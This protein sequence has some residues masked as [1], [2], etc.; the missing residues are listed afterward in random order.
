ML[1]W[2][3]S[4]KGHLVCYEDLGDVGRERDAPYEML[5]SGSL[6]NH[7]TNDYK[8]IYFG[9]LKFVVDEVG[10]LKC[11]IVLVGYQNEIIGEH[12][13]KKLYFRLVELAG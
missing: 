5:G 6:E 2:D 8:E 9:P 12:S 11:E 4:M 13:P 7:L 1:H 10:C 3:W